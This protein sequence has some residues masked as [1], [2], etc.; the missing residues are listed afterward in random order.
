METLGLGGQ[1]LRYVEVDGNF[2]IRMNAL[3]DAVASDRQA[4]RLPICVI[5][6]AGTV[7]TGA[8]DD[9]SALANF[10]RNED[11]WFHVDGAFG[12]IAA[13]TPVLRP[14]LRGMEKADSL[15]FDL[16]KWMYMPYEVLR[17]GAVPGKASQHIRL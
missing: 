2:R 11:L 8:I 5:G 3:R 12:A 7:N 1:S 6:N 14:F 10:C 9:L 4:G 13:I 15:A 17:P 16:H